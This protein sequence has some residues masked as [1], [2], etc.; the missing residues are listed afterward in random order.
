MLKRKFRYTIQPQIF[1]PTVRG[2]YN[3]YII[4]TSSDVLYVC[5]CFVIMNTQNK[6]QF[7]LACRKDMSII[8]SIDL[9]YNLTKLIVTSI[10]L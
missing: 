7:G 1:H 2:F 6:S 8:I 9:N 10:H 4:N 3:M 5:A